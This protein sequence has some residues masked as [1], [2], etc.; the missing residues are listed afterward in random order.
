MMKSTLLRSTRIGSALMAILGTLAIFWVFAP[1]SLADCKK[2]IKGE[3]YCGRGDCLRSTDGIVWCSRFEDGDAV[4]TRDG[5]VVCGRGDCEK[6][7]A[8]EVFC[9]KE[10]GGAV[11]KHRD[12]SVRCFG[13]CERATVDYCESTVAGSSE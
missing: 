11:L 2:D 12:G 8:G 3:V 7:S 5:V 9:S 6:D 10:R 13:Q 1:E 4:L